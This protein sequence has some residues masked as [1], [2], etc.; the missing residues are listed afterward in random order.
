MARSKAPRRLCHANPIPS[1]SSPSTL[2]PLFPDWLWPS[3]RFI[4]HSISPTSLKEMFQEVGRE[5][6]DV[7]R[8]TSCVIWTPQMV[9]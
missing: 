2:T 9:S 3:V 6:T 7:S 1:A 8:L 4:L 5:S